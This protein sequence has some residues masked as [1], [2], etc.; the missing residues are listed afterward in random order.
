MSKTSLF[1]QIS[2]IPILGTLGVIFQ[3]FAELPKLRHI[4]ANSIL[5]SKTSLFG[6]IS[7]IAILFTQGVI[8]Q[9]LAKSAEINAH[10]RS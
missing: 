6:Q 5:M 2:V 10:K 3:S 4:S 1:G 9:T 7:V 8:F